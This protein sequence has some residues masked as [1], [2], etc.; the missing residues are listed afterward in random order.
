MS[1]RT[2]AYHDVSS[3]RTKHKTNSPASISSIRSSKSSV[4]SVSSRDFVT[5]SDVPSI[6]QTQPDMAKQIKELYMQVNT[7]KADDVFYYLVKNK[8]SLLQ[9]FDLA[10][11][12][13]Y[14]D[15]MYPATL[16]N[17]MTRLDNLKILS[18]SPKLYNLKDYQVDVYKS[19][20]S[21]KVHNYI[22]YILSI[23][24]NT[25]VKVLYLICYNNKYY[26]SPLN[27]RSLRDDIRRKKIDTDAIDL[28]FIKANHKALREKFKLQGGNRI[29]IDPT[30]YDIILVTEAFAVFTKNA[31]NII[32]KI[33][34]QDMHHKS[35]ILGSNHIH[36]RRLQPTIDESHV[37]SVTKCYNYT[38]INTTWSPFNRYQISN[39]TP[40]AERYYCLDEDNNTAY[41]VDAVDIGWAEDDIY[42][43]HY[44]V[45][46]YF[47]LTF[48]DSVHLFTTKKEKGSRSGGGT[49][50]TGGTGVSKGSPYS[51]MIPEVSV[52][53]DIYFPDNDFEFCWFSCIINSF[54]YADDIS[55]IFLNKAIARMDKTLEYI[56]TFYENKYETFDTN[57]ARD[58]KKFVMHLINLVTFIYCSFS[59][60]S[61]NQ[62][63]KVK[64][65]SKWLE[66][67]NHVI[68]DH[69][70]YIYTFIISLSRVTKE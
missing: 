27:I 11:F 60:L 15:L 59:I 42:Y 62:I 33:N 24:D 64:N 14:K 38:M 44:K 8:I 58:L 61:K 34:P 9:K 36:N 10:V 25:A 70:Q 68:G 22:N 49:G 20:A 2:Q 12:H 50:G 46:R 48:Y 26:L 23:L 51:Q 57:S 65:K 5:D 3:K 54:F 28:D 67:Y 55:A 41:E 53:A 32:V 19:Y 39:F 17:I 40:G 52:C 45:E 6:L 63:D 31:N 56:R 30:S 37:I 16:I 66:I 29:N 43:S 35:S 18:Q 21:N 69:Y 7:E 1:K 13:F 4:S 47:D